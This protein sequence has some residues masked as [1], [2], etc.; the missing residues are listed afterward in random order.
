MYVVIGA[1]G[2]T[3]KVVAERLL[4]QGKKVRAVGRHADRLQALA[5]KGAEPFVADVTDADAIARAFIGAEGVYVMI[6][7]N[8]AAADVL[9]HANQVVGTLA[10]ALEKSGVKYA[11][12]LSSI[13][14]DKPE[15]TG[16]VLGL[17]RLEETL[18]RIS[19][20]NVLYLRA[21][22]FMENTLLWIG[23]I[24]TIG[25]AGAPVRANLKRPVI[26]T[27]DIGAAA[28][29]ALLRLNF[30]GRQTREIQGQRD[31]DYK[32]MAAIVGR[33]IGKPGLEYIQLGD[34]QLRPALQ[35][36]GMSAN[37]IDL[38]LE[39]AASVN[40]EYMRPLEKRTPLNTT[41]T[42]FETFVADTFVPLYQEQSRAE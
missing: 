42:S 25:K 35:R 33:A 20:L 6:P 13:G 16:P 18:A 22:Y 15:R 23:L 14:A 2:N 17:H 30:S 5:S 21:G 28:G 36:G 29:D 9:G 39:M 11:V 1:T 27:R 41:P 31:L 10:A 24:Q 37:M 34:V 40:S 19:G 26:A 8:D 3:G 7:P 12:A 38:L 4:S 32:E